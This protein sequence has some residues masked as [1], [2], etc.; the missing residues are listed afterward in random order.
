L[1]GFY[2][3]TKCILW[4]VSSQESGVR[5]QE[6]GVRRAVGVGDSSEASIDS[7]VRGFFEIG[8]EAGCLTKKIM[9]TIFVTGML[10]IAQL[11]T[12]QLC[13]QGSLE[14]VVKKVKDGK[15]NVRVGIFKDEKTFLKTAAWGKVVKASAGE[16]KVLFEGVPAGT[17]AVSVIHDEN[18]DGEL[19]SGMFGIPKEGFGFANDA[20]GTFGPPD[21]EKA[22]IKVGNT[23]QTIS[24]SIKY[25]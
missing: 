11:L 9:K 1:E 22:S 13:A 17:Y 15:G 6:S 14:V 2:L 4:G 18:E 5:S 7:W 3:L 24:I 16:V 25:M 23:P 10:L 8:R 19:D 21:F 12:V 20:M